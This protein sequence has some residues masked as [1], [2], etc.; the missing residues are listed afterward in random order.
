MAVVA[1]LVMHLA[2]TLVNEN[3]HL[4]CKTKKF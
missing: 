3:D 1:E 4:L 2:V